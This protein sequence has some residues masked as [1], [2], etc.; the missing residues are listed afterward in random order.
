MDHR[1]GKIRNAKASPVIMPSTPVMGQPDH[2]CI[3][4][5]FPWSRSTS[6]TQ[7]AVL[8]LNGVPQ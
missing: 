6:G 5:G 8:F 7:Q 1:I 2:S 3:D 4:T